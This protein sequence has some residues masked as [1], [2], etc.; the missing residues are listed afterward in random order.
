MVMGSISGVPAGSGAEKLWLVFQ[1]IA[2]I[3]FA[4]P[5]SVIL[6]EIQVEN[7]NFSGC[8]SFFCMNFDAWRN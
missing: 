5:Y 8:Q 6:L 1:G 3:A 7:P 2:D 4:Y